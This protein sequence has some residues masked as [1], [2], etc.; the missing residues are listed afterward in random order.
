MHAMLTSL[1]RV[2]GKTEIG[3]LVQASENQVYLSFYNERSQGSTAQGAV[4]TERLK[5]KTENWKPHIYSYIAAK[6][7]N[8]YIK[9]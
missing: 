7:F 2:K 4:K 6:I 3:K 9:K 8:I 1:V 5:R